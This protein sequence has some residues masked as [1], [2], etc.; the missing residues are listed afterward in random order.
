MNAPPKT[1]EHIEVTNK[2]IYLSLLKQKSSFAQR[3]YPRHM[4]A[5]NAY[6][7]KPARTSSCGQSEKTAH[8]ANSTP[9]IAPA[10]TDIE[11]APYF[12][13]V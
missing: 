10:P 1:T 6:R 3:H 9:S 12:P 11:N 4:F 13:A 7:I 2:L 8:L 5:T